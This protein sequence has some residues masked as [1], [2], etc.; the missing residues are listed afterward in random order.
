MRFIQY[1]ELQNVD[2][3]RLRL[4]PFNMRS[5]KVI[6]PMYLDVTPETSKTLEDTLYGHQLPIFLEILPSDDERDALPPFDKENDVI[7]FI[8]MYDPV[9]ESLHYYGHWCVPICTT[10]SKF[11]S[12]YLIV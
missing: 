9:N 8:K 10:F 3:K 5:T 4:W 12:K 2:T 6:R 1:D 11:I 7:L